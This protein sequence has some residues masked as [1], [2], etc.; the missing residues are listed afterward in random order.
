MGQFDENP[1]IQLNFMKCSCS[2][3]YRNVIIVCEFSERTSVLFED[4]TRDERIPSLFM[5]YLAGSVC[6]ALHQSLTKICLT[7]PIV[8]GIWNSL[9]HP[10]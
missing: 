9:K 3:R 2:F 8:A 4:S 6:P 7:L 5:P 1:L 10:F